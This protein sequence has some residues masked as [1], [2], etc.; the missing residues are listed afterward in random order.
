ME[1]ND[2]DYCDRLPGQHTGRL[3][4][5]LQASEAAEWQEIVDML[6]TRVRNLENEVSKLKASPAAAESPPISAEEAQAHAGRYFPK[7][8]AD[9]INTGIQVESSAKTSAAVG[10]SQFSFVDTIQGS[11]CAMWKCSQCAAIITSP[12]LPNGECPWC[13]F[14][15]ELPKPV[16]DSKPTNCHSPESEDTP[17]RGNDVPAT[18]EPFRLEYGKRYLRRDGEVS[19]EMIATPTLNE[20]AATHPFWDSD[21]GLSYR[22]DG[23]YV[24]DLEPDL[25]D[26]IDEYHEPVPAESPEKEN[27]LKDINVGRIEGLQHVLDCIHSM[28]TAGRNAVAAQALAE[29]QTVCLAAIQRINEGSSLSSTSQVDASPPAESPDDWV[30]LTDPEHRIRRVDECRKIDDSGVWTPCTAS[31]GGTVEVWH[32]LQFRCRR[33]DLP[34]VPVEFPSLASAKENPNGLHQKYI[35]TRVD[36]KPIDPKAV[37]FV[38]RLDG[39]HAHN[40]ASRAAALKWAEVIDHTCE[41]LGM[42]S[43]DLRGLVKHLTPVPVVPKT[44]TVT[45]KSYEMHGDVVWTSASWI[46]GGRTCVTEVPE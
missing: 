25:F 34:P 16:S 21:H 31:V 1:A 2:D 41:K 11:N 44:R 12:S 9:A 39:N 27:P 7:E 18:D 5:E 30:M 13:G 10:A 46:H 8:I 43:N 15:T 36:G 20:Y 14:S 3:S 33:K 23:S 32:D 35:I 24:D 37:Y 17:P 45:L 28:L 38:L 40:N 22:S 6:A 29:V 19:V 42:V 4:L 26:L